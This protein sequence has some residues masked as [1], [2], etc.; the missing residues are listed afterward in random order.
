MIQ[1]IICYVLVIFM[2]IIDTNSYSL[3]INANKIIN[4]SNI[5]N[6]NNQQSNSIYKKNEKNNKIY[7]ATTENEVMTQLGVVTMYK[8]E[9]IFIAY[10]YY[11]YA[12]IYVYVCWT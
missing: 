3:Q 12:C 5:K 4:H 11:I 6:I 9:G 10:I 2:C 8:K 1:Q 7:M